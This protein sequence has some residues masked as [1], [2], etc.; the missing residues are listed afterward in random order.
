[1]SPHPPETLMGLKTPFVQGPG[2]NSTNSYHDLPVKFMDLPPLPKYS[3][4]DY[5][6]IVLA[7][8]RTATTTHHFCHIIK[9]LRQIRAVTFG[10]SRTVNTCTAGNDDG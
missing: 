10:Y 1:M 6:H 9:F 2:L 3:I 4:D 5:F 7:Q 8:V